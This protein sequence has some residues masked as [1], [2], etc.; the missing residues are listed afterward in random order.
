MMHSQANIKFSAYQF[1][2]ALHFPDIYLL[3]HIMLLNLSHKVHASN[4][5]P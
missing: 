2:T 1:T 3:Q 5:P 4:R